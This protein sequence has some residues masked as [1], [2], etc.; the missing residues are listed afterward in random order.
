MGRAAQI[1]GFVNKHNQREE[2]FPGPVINYG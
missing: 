2:D 1:T